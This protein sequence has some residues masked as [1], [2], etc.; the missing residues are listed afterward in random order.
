MTLA[1]VF[2]RVVVMMAYLVEV[3]GALIILYCELRQTLTWARYAQYFLYFQMGH[4]GIECVM[5]FAGVV[6]MVGWTPRD[7]IGHHL[8]AFIITTIG[9]WQAFSDPI[10]F[11][12]IMM[13]SKGYILRLMLYSAFTTSCNE[14]FYI[15]RSFFPDPN[16]KCFEVVHPYI[17]WLVLV[18]QIIIGVPCCVLC[19]AH[20]EWPLYRETGSWMLIVQMLVVGLG[21]PVF[22]LLYQAPLVYGLSKKIGRRYGCCLKRSIKPDSMYA[23]LADGETPCDQSNGDRA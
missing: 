22:H 13:A 4:Y 23:P 7:L 9:Y 14:A 16:A 11:D 2:C 20:V 17:R 19:V 6:N 1:P 12:D 15:I 21:G 5:A 3:V 18:Q 8:P 10:F